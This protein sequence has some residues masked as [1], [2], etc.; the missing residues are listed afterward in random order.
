[1]NRHLGL[2]TVAT[3][4]PQAGKVITP[5]R[6]FDF[7]RLLNYEIY[8]LLRSGCGVSRRLI[9]HADTAV[10]HAIA[11]GSQCLRE[12]T[13]TRDSPFTLPSFAAGAQPGRHRHLLIVAGIKKYVEP[14]ENA[15]PASRAAS[16]GCALLL[17]K[18]RNG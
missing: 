7:V 10:T 15:M 1:V 8:K 13:D 12:S 14:G 4:S 9:A 5:S 11:S 18:R 17:R 6:K 2:T 16:R 3:R